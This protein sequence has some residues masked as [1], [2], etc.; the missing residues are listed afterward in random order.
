MPNND[1]TVRAVFESRQ[2][3]GTATFNLSGQMSATLQSGQSGESSAVSVN[4]TTLPAGAEVS[5]ISI[6]I[7]NSSGSIIPSILIVTCSSR[8]NHEMQIPWTGQMNTPIGGDRLDF[9]SFP[10]NELWTVSWYGTNT[11]I[12]PQPQTRTFGNV[13]LTIEYTYTVD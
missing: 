10:A 13:S 12:L 6:N 11:S 5:R 3:L 2:R 7:G 9:W 4:V 1:V 8:P